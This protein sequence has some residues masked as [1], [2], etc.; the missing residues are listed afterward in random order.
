[1][2]VAALTPL[3][4]P[5]GRPYEPASPSARMTPA[6][7]SRATSSPTL[8][9]T[10]TPLE[11]SSGQ[12]F[13]DALATPGSKSPPGE[14]PSLQGHV[15]PHALPAV[16]LVKDPRQ[17]RQFYRL[18]RLKG[19]HAA[20]QD[21]GL[22]EFATSKAEELLTAARE[23]GDLHRLVAFQHKDPFKRYLFLLEAEQLAQGVPHDT[24]RRHLQACVQE[25]QTALWDAH[26]EE[27]AS[28]FDT[29]QSF[30]P[31]AHGLQGWDDARAI[32]R[33]WVTQSPNL[34]ALYRNLN[35]AFEPR[36]LRMGL[37][38][39]RKA[40]RADLASPL[41]QTGAS[42]RVSQTLDLERVGVLERLMDSV[43]RFMKGARRGR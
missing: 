13:R 40:L 6:D 34:V 7:A 42:R 4:P 32:Y 18:A 17:L 10:P 24:D 3:S 20:F 28:G 16:A 22:R 33:E 29:A 26:A 43:D 19:L 30:L 5:A 8:A 14:R 21:L 23:G 41:A 25:V 9:R 1:M 35:Q 37:I 38:S 2:A 36:Q 39:V 12:V 11:A 27:I 15:T 31:I